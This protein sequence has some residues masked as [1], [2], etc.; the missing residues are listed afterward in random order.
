MPDEPDAIGR[1]MGEALG[2]LGAPIGRAVV[3]HDE[4]EIG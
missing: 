1:G 3:D 2:D 4:P